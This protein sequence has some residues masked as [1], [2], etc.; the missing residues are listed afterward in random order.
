MK[1]L[2]P[3][4]GFMRGLSDAVDAIWINILMLV[5][6]IPIITIGAALTAGHDAVRRTLS[7]EGTATR[8]YFKAFRSNF[9]KSTG[10]WLIFGTTG[11]LCVYSWIVLQ[12]T[13]LL[14]PKFALTI[15]W[16]IGFEWVWALQARFENSFWRTLG[17]AFVFGVSNIGHTLALVAID[18]VYVALD[19]K[20]V[21]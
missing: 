19:R 5:T 16:L 15:V 4:S 3:D 17:N 6:S 8:N 14:I 11:T 7:G 2:S 9:A 21:V 10:Y 13:P 12:I 20:S 1:F 18:A